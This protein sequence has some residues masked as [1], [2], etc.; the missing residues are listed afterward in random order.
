MNTRQ[1]VTL[2]HKLHSGG[3]N[4]SDGYEHLMVDGRLE[5]KKF[6][7]FVCRYIKEEKMVFYANS[8]LVGFGDIQD[9]F[10][11]TV[12]NMAD[13]RIRIA[14]TDFQGKII[15]EPTGVG[16]GQLTSGR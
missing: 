12:R 3:V 14:S 4:T 6:K 7:S 13:N 9:A 10:E 16:I 8:Q 15:I 2:M 5:L 11:F 1:I